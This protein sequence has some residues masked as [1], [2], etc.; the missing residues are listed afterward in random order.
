MLLIPLGVFN[1]IVVYILSK[2]SRKTGEIHYVGILGTI[3]SLVGAIILCTLP[4]SPVKLIGVYLA[5][6][7]FINVFSQASI[8][9]N[10]S[11]STK[12]ILYTNNN[13]VGYGLGHL[14]GPLMMVESQQPRYTMP[15]LGY[16]IA[17]IISIALIWYIRW[18]YQQENRRRETMQDAWTS[19]LS[20]DDKQDLTDKQD[21][22]FRYKL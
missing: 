9:S 13:I 20:H 18:S 1:G 5:P 16:I 19:S 8:S 3:I 12:K 6:N 7:V 14:L 21:V 17:D 11:G 10:V 4:N 15:L 22:H 2:L